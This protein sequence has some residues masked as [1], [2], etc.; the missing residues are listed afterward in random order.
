MTKTPRN[1]PRHAIEIVAFPGVQLLDVTGPLQVFASANDAMRVS[2]KPP[3]YEVRMV[4]RSSPV[5]SSSGLALVAGKLPRGGHPVDTLI[6]S[7]AL[8][9]VDM[10]EFEQLGGLIHEAVIVFDQPSRA[11]QH[12][13]EAG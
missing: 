4:A 3:F 10:K 13:L 2:G 12:R 5:G 8:G 9:V 11:S 6:A 1:P 7:G